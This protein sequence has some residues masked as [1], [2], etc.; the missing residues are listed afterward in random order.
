[1]LCVCVCV[2]VCVVLHILTL[3]R[4]RFPA[5]CVR[6]AQVMLLRSKQPHR[7]SA[8]AVMK[9]AGVLQLREIMGLSRQGLNSLRQRGSAIPPATDDD[10]GGGSNVLA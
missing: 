9:A 3:V 2:C 10:D 8:T 4:S 6:G 7:V 5:L 1:M